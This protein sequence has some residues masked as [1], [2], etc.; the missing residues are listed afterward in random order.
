MSHSHS[1]TTSTGSTGHGGLIVPA[2]LRRHRRALRI[3]VVVLIPLAIWT[4]VGLIAFWPGDIS[5]NVNKEVAGYN[6]PGVTYPTAKITGVEETSCDGLAGS[7]TGTNVARCANVTAALTGAAM[8]TLLILLGFPVS[9]AALIAA[10][11]AFFVRGGAL[12]FGWSFPGY[13]ARPGRRPE[14]I[15]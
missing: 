14:D 9:V 8:Y 15:P 4:L 1:S 6:V 10:P 11:A 5:A 13:R 3:L 7:T 12:R 2:E